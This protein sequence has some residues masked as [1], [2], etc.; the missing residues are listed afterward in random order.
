MT[1]ADKCCG[2]NKRGDLD[3]P[4]LGLCAT[5]SKTGAAAMYDSAGQNSRDA[6]MSAADFCT[7]S[8]S[9]KQVLDQLPPVQ[10]H[11]TFFSASSHTIFD[12]CGNDTDDSCSV[13]MCKNTATEQDICLASPQ[14][15]ERQTEQNAKAASSSTECRK[16]IFSEEKLCLLEKVIASGNISF[17]GSVR[18]IV[19]ENA[20]ELVAADENVTESEMK[21]YELTANFSAL[22]LRIPA[23][24]VKLLQSA[25]GQKWLQ[26]QLA[27]LDA[28]FRFKDGACPFIVGV[29]WETSMGAKSRLEKML[30]SKTVPFADQHTSFLQSVQWARAVEK[31][32]SEYF[33][34]VST[35]YRKNEIVVE[36]SNETLADVVGSI[37]MLLKQNGRLQRKITISKEQF[38]LLLVHK[39]EIQDK[40]ESELAL[41]QQQHRYTSCSC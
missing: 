23:G 34:T 20:V 30:L 31:F 8:D 4:L 38:D 25:R 24:V 3:K 39:G 14:K 37:S 27:G 5:Y 40:L 21:L 9:V 17:P 6:Q 36:G 16:I 1:L 19:A 12:D 28:V 32:E 10:Q 13:G 26:L 18:V 35:E 22:S 15:S 33:A 11:Q 7:L 41:Q 2:D 29:D